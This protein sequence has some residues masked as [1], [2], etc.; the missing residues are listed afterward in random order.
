MPLVEGGVPEGV[1]EG[2]EE[3]GS[4]ASEV[5]VKKELLKAKEEKPA[6]LERQEVSD[7]RPDYVSRHQPA[8]TGVRNV[9]VVRGARTKIEL[10]KSRSKSPLGDFSKPV[11]LQQKGNGPRPLAPA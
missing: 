8:Q 4:T 2:S 1:R 3:T 7:Y 11:W 6:T 5:K 10:S 9:D